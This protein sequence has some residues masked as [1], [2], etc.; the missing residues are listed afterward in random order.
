MSKKNSSVN[1][2]SEYKKAAKSSEWTFEKETWGEK[3]QSNKKKQKKKKKNPKSFEL[4][5]WERQKISLRWHMQFR[6]EGCNN[7]STF[8]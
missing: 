5:Y 7:T 3:E 8:D 6:D 2:S 1:L 4:I